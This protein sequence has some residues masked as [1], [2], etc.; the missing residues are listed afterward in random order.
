MRENPKVCGRCKEFTPLENG[1]GSC[2][3]CTGRIST[4]EPG[5]TKWEEKP[6]LGIVEK[7]RELHDHPDERPEAKTVLQEIIRR[8]EEI[9]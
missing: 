6:L 5:C 8:L 4:E 1:V 7:L 3:W 2:P 9:S